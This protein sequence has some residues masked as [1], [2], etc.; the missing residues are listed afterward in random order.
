VTSLSGR[1]VFELS[2]VQLSFSNNNRIKADFASAFFLGLNV[3]WN[4]LNPGIIGLS[5]SAYASYLHKSK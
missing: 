1:I 2:C 3:I 5:K 4:Q